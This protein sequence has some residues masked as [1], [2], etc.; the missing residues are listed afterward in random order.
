[1]SFRTTQPKVSFPYQLKS[2]T[3][4]RLIFPSTILS[5]R[6]NR[7]MV[8]PISQLSKTKSLQIKIQVQKEGLNGLES[9]SLGRVT[10]LVSK[11]ESVLS[12]DMETLFSIS[13]AYH[14][15]SMFL[16]P[17]MSCQMLEQ[18]IKVLDEFT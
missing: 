18:T 17:L 11:S 3:H 9:A 6:C 8:S 16:Y 15:A 7:F 1:M 14:V 5:V 13:D 4:L 12:S 10:G 2:F